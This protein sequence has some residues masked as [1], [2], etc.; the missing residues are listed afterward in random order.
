MAKESPIKRPVVRLPEGGQLGLFGSKELQ[1]SERHAERSGKVI[2]NQGSVEDLFIGSVRVE[3]H[4]RV[5]GER[6]AFVVREVLS[7]MDFRELESGYRPGGRR[8]Y[9]PRSMLGLVL[10]GVMQGVT[11]LRELERLARVN[12]GCMWA[13]GGITPDH[14]VIGRFLTQHESQLSESQVSELTRGVL[15]RTGSGTRTVAGDGTVIQAAGSA[16]R[17]L[18]LEA[19]RAAS[20]KAREAAEDSPEDEGLRAKAAKAKEVKETL[21][22]RVEARRSKGKEGEHLRISA[23]EPEAVSQPM[24]DKRQAPSYKPSVLANEMRVVLGLAVHPSSETGVVSSL[25]D[26]AQALGEVEELLVDAGYHCDEVIDETLA[27]DIS[28]L[29]PQGRTHDEGSWTKHEGKQIP[30]SE[31]IYDAETDTYGCPQGERLV[32]VGRFRGSATQPG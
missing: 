30:K 16:Y 12:L 24:K 8:P 1:G 28:L 6:E 2:F 20:D 5:T 7:E 13:S 25:L 32:V 18:K 26:Q 19:A 29:C 31:F 10:Y 4:L 21:E 27:R 11:S 22:E 3:E 15:G 17:Q 14:S 23:T 9:S